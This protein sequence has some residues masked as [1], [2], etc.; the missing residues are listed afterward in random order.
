VL[1]KEERLIESTLAQSA[2]VQGNRNER[3]NIFHVMKET[4][5]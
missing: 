4:G 3:V 2:G 1:G 5:K